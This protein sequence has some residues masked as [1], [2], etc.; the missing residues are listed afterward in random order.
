MKES[1]RN[2]LAPRGT[3][4][5]E[6]VGEEHISETKGQVICN[7]GRREMSKPDITGMSEGGGDRESW[8]REIGE[9]KTDGK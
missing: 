8:D 6:K 9:T 3:E 7:R 4:T 1:Q 5:T 2:I